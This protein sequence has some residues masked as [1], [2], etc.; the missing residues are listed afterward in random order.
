MQTAVVQ[1]AALG[2]VVAGGGV[3]AAQCVLARRLQAP[4]SFAL[5]L[6]SFVGT[7]CHVNSQ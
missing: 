3:A 1:H 4:G 5:A 2:A 6:G 7:L